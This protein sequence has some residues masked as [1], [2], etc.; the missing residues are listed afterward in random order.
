M[1][2][3]PVLG[4]APEEAGAGRLIG[5]SAPMRALRHRLARVARSSA[6]VFLTGESGVGKDLCAEAIHAA[7]TRAAHPLIA[8][9]CGAIPAGLIEAALFGHRRG[10][11]TGAVADSKGA[12]AAADGG[13][14]FLDEICELPLGLQ[15]RLL[16]FL[17]TGAVA[18]VGDHASRPVDVRIISATNRDPMA[19]MAA[20]RL[21]EDLFYRLH[22]LPVHT[23]PLRERRGDVTEIA[24]AFLARFANEE[25]KRFEGFTTDALAALEAAPWPGNVRQLRNAIRQAVVMGDGG[26]IC[27]A[28]L[29][30]APAPR[31]TSGETAARAAEALI[32]LPFHEIERLV[33]VA[34]IERFGS[35]PKAARAL[36]L[37]PST[38]YRKQE[39]WAATTGED[40]FGPDWSKKI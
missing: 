16:R 8:L 35:A 24:A 19:E 17:E 23:P 15:T 22:V 21:R 25:G 36:G 27:P 40:A 38:V 6:A 39:A 34:A 28:L 13:T 4:P 37:S 20:G 9:N 26:R 5:G 12:A 18:P 14:L 29:G 2:P 11:F 10:A 7:S 33:L 32:G 3:E 30:L 31:S 1:K